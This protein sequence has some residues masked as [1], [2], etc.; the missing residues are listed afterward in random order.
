M[1]DPADTPDEEQ[2]YECYECGTIIAA[3]SPPGECQKCGA[4]LR[5]RRYPLE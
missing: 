5:N 3:E 2:T 4:D 1:R